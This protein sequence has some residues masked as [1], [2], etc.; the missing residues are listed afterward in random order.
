SLRTVG[1]GHISSISFREGIIDA[2]GNLNLWPQPA[3]A[4]A[5]ETETPGVE[6]EV[7]ALKSEAAPISG[8]VLFPVTRAQRNGLEDLRLVRFVEDDG[9]A[10]YY[11]TYT[12]YSGT[13]IGSEL[14][15]TSDFSVFK[16]SPMNGAASGNK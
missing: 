16:L 9:A 11:G 12:A 10:T 2:K 8:T 7:I 13:G 14:L 1:E 6:G 5:A 3:F 4:I 15:E